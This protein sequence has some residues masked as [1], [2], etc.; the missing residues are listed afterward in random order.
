MRCG[1]GERTVGGF[2]ARLG[3]NDDA[4][5]DVAAC[6]GNI[7][8]LRCCFDEHEPRHRAHFAEALPFRRSSSAAAGHLDAKSS[9]IVGGIDR[10]R[11]DFDF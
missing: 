2:S 3:V 4:L 8:F 1:V 7:P 6:S 11:F 9:V 10:S 5:C